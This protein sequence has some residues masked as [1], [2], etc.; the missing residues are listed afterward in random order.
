MTREQEAE[1][2][3][4]RGIFERP[5]GSGIWWISYFGADG[6]HHREKVGHWQRAIDL[7]HR[8]RAAVLEGRGRDLP[9]LTRRRSMSF[10]ELAQAR[11]EEKKTRNAP[12]SL[13]SDRFRLAVLLKELGN[14]PA[15]SISAD[16]I[17]K[18]L[19]RL[20]DGQDNSKSRRLIDGKRS[21]STINRYRSLLS[22][23][24][25]HG[26]RAGVVEANP[27]MRVDRFRENEHRIRFLDA[28][29]EKA[30]RA[31]IRKRC[32]AREPELDLALH[33][34]LRRG[35]QFGLTWERVDL[36]R[37]ILTVRGKTGRRFVPVNSIARA[38]LERL[39]R[40]S[41][42]HSFVCPE[43]KREDQEDWRRWF[44]EAV[45]EAK[46]DNFTW[47]DLRHTFAS[48]LAM[49][50]VPLASVQQ[51]LGHRS[52]LTTMRYAHLSPDFQKKNIEK[53]VGGK[54]SEARKIA[55]PQLAPK[56]APPVSATRRGEEKAAS[57]Q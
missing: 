51:Y 17:A 8:R 44:E 2:K 55:R 29:E 3:K 35:E 49:K 54:R 21:G 5:L 19:R 41:N 4:Q 36:E 7:Y 11:M 45:S 23:I 42:G 46:I 50:A 1:G 30:L 31:V 48:R 6:K 14:E 9:V 15:R 22:S 39:W 34:G 33:T 56:L 16:D 12:K 43:A 32:P 24:F 52:I 53:L 47:H 13:R 18:L 10:R 37:G 26:V 20:Q 25:R 57:N 40:Q 28:G 38:A 27:V